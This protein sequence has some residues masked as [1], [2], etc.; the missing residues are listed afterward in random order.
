MKITKQRLK[1]IIK[2]AI[3]D[4]EWAG[5]PTEADRDVARARQKE[6]KSFEDVAAA[7][8]EIRE[9]LDFLEG[10]PSNAPRISS[11]WGSEE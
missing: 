4:S 2:E 8:S 6:I 11:A 3:E 10:A 7:I 5:S 9:R 1:E